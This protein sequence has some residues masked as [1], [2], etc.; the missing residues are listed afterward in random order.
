MTETNKL[1]AKPDQTLF[2]HT[3]KVYYNWQKVIE[4]INN[5]ELPFLNEDIREKSLISV[6][7]HDVGKIID[8]FQKMM[9]SIKEKTKINKFSY[10]RHELF[11]GIIVSLLI[12]DDFLPAAS[13]FTHHKSFN[14]ELFSNES[15]Q[16][17]ILNIN[18]LKGVFHYYQKILK[19]DIRITNFP[20][21]GIKNINAKKCCDSFNRLKNK[22]IQKIGSNERLRYIFYKGILQLCDWTASAN[23]QLLDD[24]IIEREKLKN[25]LEILKKTK[26]SF[27]DFQMECLKSEKDCLVVAPTGSGKTEASLLWAGEKKG[28]IIY[29][30]P[31]RVTSNAIYKRIKYFCGDKNVGLVHSSAFLYQKEL[32]NDYDRSDYLLDKTFYKPVTVATIDQ[33]LSCGFNAGFWEM[34]EFN[35]IKSKIIVDEIHS[36]DFY[37][38][39][40]IINMIKHF[41]HLNTSFFL[42]TATIPK[43]LKNLILKEIPYI[44]FIQN[45]DLMEKSRNEFNIYEC[46]VDDLKDR[47]TSE[48]QSEKKILI[49]VNSVNEAI[50]LYEEYKDITKKLI[51][52]HSRFIMDDRNKKEKQIE[53]VSNNESDINLVI[54]TQVV[55]VSLDI[56][57]DILF[58]EN[59]PADSIIQRAGRVNRK[60][61]KQNTSVN[62]FKHSEISEKIYEPKILEKTFHE[63]K[64][65][66]GKTLKEHE[67]IEIIENVYKDINIF[68]IEDFQ[69]GLNKYEEIQKHYNY[70]QD[71]DPEDEK[72]YTRN[73]DEKKISIIPM[74]FKDEL[75]DKDPLTKSKYE[76][77]VPVYFLKNS[78]NI[79]EDGF[80]YCDIDYSY[81]KGVEFKK[82]ADDRHKLIIL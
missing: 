15:N 8:S 32:N 21:D 60:R 18:N 49:V 53:E 36:Y 72:I 24:I 62:I 45:K 57:F 68:E 63:F 6:I 1:H 65:K 56:D 30:L 76:V 78:K 13:V 51:C 28:K 17:L 73:F 71:V 50:R 47:I 46:P 52:Y 64:Y 4:K 55:E 7:F 69:N 80:I 25:H 10:L 70:I 58:T 44:Q 14:N 37:T 20:F 41:K 67:L 77:D 29:L 9:I 40:L 26:I 33:L 12:K 19:N 48:I 22:S 38:L 31:T 43:F 66:D 2:E 79:K 27:N 34:K 35:S 54:T 5:S 82:K 74:K 11:S 42:M 39:G 81:E 3:D 16:E 23:A 61:H 59:A 75:Q